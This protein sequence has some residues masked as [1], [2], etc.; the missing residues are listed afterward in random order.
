[1]E[2]VRICGANK[3]FAKPSD[4]NEAIDGPCDDLHV[5]KTE[6]QMRSAW[7]PTNEEIDALMAG[8][9]VLIAV[10][11]QALPPLMVGVSVDNTSKMIGE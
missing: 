8:E 5:L 1:M 10:F 11:G 7:H 3:V 2:A 6:T 9:V 4:W